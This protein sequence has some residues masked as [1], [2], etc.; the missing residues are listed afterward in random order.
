MEFQAH[1][2]HS[3][4]YF[5]Y[6]PEK[7]IL[8]SRPIDGMFS[9]KSKVITKEM[10]GSE[11]LYKVENMFGEQNIKSTEEGFHFQDDVYVNVSQED[12]YFF[13]REGNR[14]EA[15]LSNESSEKYSLV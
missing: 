3:E 12:L 13:D 7:A 8:D 10:L 4:E 5:G 9:L 2:I 14:M 1:S 11:S 15:S 6:R